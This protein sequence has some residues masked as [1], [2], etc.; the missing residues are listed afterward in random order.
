MWNVRAIHWSLVYSCHM[1]GSVFRCGYSLKLRERGG[2]GGGRKQ[3]PR[4]TVGSPH[5]TDL[6]LYYAL[7]EV[8]ASDPATKKSLKITWM[9]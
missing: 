5:P 1:G 8:P 9:K 4:G 3:K 6:F 2:K 7:A